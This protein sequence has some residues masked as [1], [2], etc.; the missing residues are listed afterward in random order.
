MTRIKLM[1]LAL[2]AAFAF[3]AV[4]VASAQA[5]NPI[6]LVCSKVTTGKFLDQDCLKEGSGGK[7]E[8]LLFL[9]GE[10][11][12]LKT[13]NGEA[14]L[15]SATKEVITCENGTSGGEITSEDSISGIVVKFTK[16]KGH[17]AGQR[18]NAR[19]TARTR[20]QARVKSSR[21]H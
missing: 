20:Q 7:W 16:C 19:S 3:A 6:L 5:A 12:P 18:K 14:T 9:A 21:I 11:L 1:G 17:K 4:A 10:K 15:E 8:K 2:F 13:T